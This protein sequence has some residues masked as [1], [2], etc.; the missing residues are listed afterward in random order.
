ME[1]EVVNLS[2]QNANPVGAAPLPLPQTPPKR[3]PI[4]SLVAFLVLIILITLVYAVFLSKNAAPAGPDLSQL[5]GSTVKPEEKKAL[6]LTRLQMAQA[7]PLS[8]AESRYILEWIAG[9]EGRTVNLT[10]QEKMQIIRAIN[11]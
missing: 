4:L 8:S 10:P 5:V 1:N 3:N 7:Q 11:K 9:G 6:L 2:G